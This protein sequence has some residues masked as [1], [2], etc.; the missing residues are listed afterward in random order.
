MWDGRKDGFSALVHY[1]RLD[2]AA[3]EKLTYAT[4]G[5]WLR[6]QQAAVDAGEPASDARL[7]AAR[8]LQ[9]KL[10]LILEG[11]PPHDL[12][13]RWKPLAQQPLG[14]E[15]DL[16]DGVRLN[17]RPFITAGILRKPPKVHWNKDRGK[18]V[19]TAPWFATFGGD[20]IND[21]HLTLAE[22]RAARESA[23]Q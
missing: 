19:P 15:P 12:F 8:E 5:D 13:I 2:R 7:A 18:D 16:N 11:E 22:K 4:L 21:H 14:W 3:L 1:H 23:G 20:R 9:A 10:K 17:L 6:R